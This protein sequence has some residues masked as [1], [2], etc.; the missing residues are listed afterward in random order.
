MIILRLCWILLLFAPQA[1]AAW[2]GI[3]NNVPD[4]PGIR[5][6]DTILRPAG[7]SSFIV[8]AETQLPECAMS[9]LPVTM[10][11]LRWAKIV[12]RIEA[13]ALSRGVI[14]KSAIGETRTAA[15]QEI[16]P[17][18]E[19]GPAPASLPLAA[20]LIPRLSVTAFGSANRASIKQEASGIFLDCADGNTA[21]GAL[22]RSRAGTLPPGASIA[23]KLDVDANGSFRF[24]TADALREKLGEPLVLGTINPGTSSPQFPLPADLQTEFWRFWVISCPAS[25]AK[26]AIRSIQL[27]PQQSRSTTH[28]ALWVW[29]PSAW[30]K[31]PEA[32]LKLLV[33]NA[34]NTVFVT[35]PLTPGNSRVA[36][37]AVLERFVIQASKAGVSVWAVVG[38]PLAVL[39][40]GRRQYIDMARAYAAYNRGAPPGAGLA[41][42]QLDIEPY[43]NRGYHI[44]T[45]GWL[46]AYLETLSQVRA[47]A[48][49][50]LDVAVPFWWGRQPYR[51]GMFLDH[52]RPLVEVVTV[53]N[54]RTER[55]QLVDFAEPFLAWGVRARKSIRIGLEAGPLPDESQH[56][57]RNS[58]QGDLWLVPLGANA[59]M[60]SLNTARANPAGTAFHF[61]HTLNRKSNN[62]TFHQNVGTMRKLLPELESKWHAWPS[63]GGIALHGLDSD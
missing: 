10:E 1:T 49:M 47:H 22:L 7:I 13:E 43:L 37:P 36:D 14:L 3:C 61:S 4:K 34:A 60:L 21:A 42:L 20:E 5:V 17:L 54:Y 62:I 30:L 44:D 16:I 50:P 51:D 9:E 24:G 40:E 45:E 26:L 18:H 32:L 19:N 29:E 57:F 59:L 33:E 39:P 11:Q 31:R 23:V 2:F 38:D 28:R 63:F 56:I 48:A 53:M 15:P 46:S 58:A 35:I 8:A 27:Q 12:S 25:S 52:L 55:Q 6:L 41:G